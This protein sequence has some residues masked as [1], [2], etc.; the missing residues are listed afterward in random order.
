[1]IFREHERRLGS[2]LGLELFGSF[3]FNSAHDIKFER[4][5][6]WICWDC[7]PIFQIFYRLALRWLYRK[8]KKT[9]QNM[10]ENFK[11]RSNISRRYLAKYWYLSQEC[12]QIPNLLFKL[13]YLK[14]RLERHFNSL[15]CHPHL[16]LSVIPA[17]VLYLNDVIWSYKVVRAPH[18][19]KLRILRTK[20]RFG[21]LNK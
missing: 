2:R 14:L 3:W 17:L 19:V 6:D 1:M 8:L 11:Q 16:H 5:D 7:F 10:V 4:W 12:Q 20:P 18:Y 9:H 21:E 15:G 13:E